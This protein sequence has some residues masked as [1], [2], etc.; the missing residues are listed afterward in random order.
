MQAFRKSERIKDTNKARI[1]RIPIQDVASSMMAGN[2]DI[3]NQNN[4]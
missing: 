2:Y 3:W 4:I 1:D